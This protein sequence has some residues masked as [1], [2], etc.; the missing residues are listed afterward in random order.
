[1][2][3]LQYGEGQVREKSHSKGPRDDGA[4]E[5]RGKGGTPAPGDLEAMDEALRGR[6]EGCGG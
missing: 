5:R 1:M 4:V 2:E 3:G 6:H